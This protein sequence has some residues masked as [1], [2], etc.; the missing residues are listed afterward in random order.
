MISICGRKV[1]VSTR[2]KSQTINICGIDNVHGRYDYVVRLRPPF[3]SEGDLLHQHFGS[4]PDLVRYL[5]RQHSGEVERTPVIRPSNI[6]VN[7]TLPTDAPAG[8]RAGTAGG[9]GGWC[10]AWDELGDF[11]GPELPGP[12]RRIRDLLALWEAPVP[13]SWMRSGPDTPGRLISGQ[14][15]TRGNLHGARRGEHE[16]EYEILVTHFEKVRWLGRPLLD[17]VNAYPLTRD[18]G[19]ARHDNVEAD[20]VLLAG[21]ADSASLLVADVKVT[22]GNTWTALVQNLRQLRLF[23]ANASCLSL[24]EQRGVETN[25]TAICGAVIAPRVFYSGKGKKTNSVQH[26][27]ELAASMLRAHKVPV[28]LL[29][30]T[31]RSAELSRYR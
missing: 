25:V 2:T 22:D 27:R 20:L 1:K 4:I 10:H 13:G 17:G 8:P 9:F 29:V 21:S 14:R 15:Y 7:S 5:E 11:N 28:D 26:A 31:P 16:I 12:H 6:V 3:I 18:S 24:F 30:W 23:T 19:G